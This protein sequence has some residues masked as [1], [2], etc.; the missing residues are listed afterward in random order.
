VRLVGFTIEMYYDARPSE[1]Q[2]YIRYFKSKLSF[3]RNVKTSIDIMTYS[4]H[5]TH[6]T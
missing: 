3:L 5:S 4:L 6:K 1:R 2:I